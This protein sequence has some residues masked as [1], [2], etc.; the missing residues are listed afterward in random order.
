M[1]SQTSCFGLLTA[2]IHKTIINTQSMQREKMFNKF[3]DSGIGISHV[4]C[5]AVH[6]NFRSSH[7]PITTLATHDGQTMN[8]VTVVN[9][10]LAL[11]Q[12]TGRVTS[13]QQ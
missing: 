5:L 13:I 4:L 8:A 2:M 3:G 1:N 12:H 9:H 7:T 6:T 10:L 11:Y